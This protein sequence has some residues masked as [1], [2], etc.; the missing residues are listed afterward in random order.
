MKKVEGMKVVLNEYMKEAFESTRSR[1]ELYMKEKDT[2]MNKKLKR[3]PE[4][5]AGNIKHSK[6][7][8][9]SFK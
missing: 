7:I 8:R 4:N 3:I 5:S 6:R 2:Q 1:M 9:S